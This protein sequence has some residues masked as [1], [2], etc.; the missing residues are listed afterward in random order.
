MTFTKIIPYFLALIFCSIQTQTFATSFFPSPLINADWLIENRDEH[1][2]ILDARKDLA[3]F[4]KEGHIEGAILVDNKKVRVDKIVDGKTLSR[5]RPNAQQ[6]EAFMQQH[7]IN[8]NSHVVI[9]HKGE[10]PGQVAGATRLYWHFKLYNF[11]DVALLDGGNAAWVEA[12]EDLTTKIT[13]IHKGNYTVGKDNL[14]T[15]A[16]RQHVISAINNK[17]ATLIDSRSLRFHIG[18]NKKSYVF[19]YGHIP[20][21]KLV[22]YKF[23]NPLKGIA[24]FATKQHIKDTLNAMNIDLNSNKIIYCNSGYEASAVWFA[25]HELLGLKNTKIYDGS[26]HEWTQYPENKLVK[27]INGNTTSI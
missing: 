4:I 19:D 5:M 18:L 21:S 3:S 13:K 9:T 26:L 17:T 27:K 22:Y 24:K 8:K 15:L 23:L 7:G 11:N 16:T 20:S 1:T 14:T 25:L 12:L 6:F 2:V 10:T